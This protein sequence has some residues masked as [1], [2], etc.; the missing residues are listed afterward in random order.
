[1]A[2]V[3]QKKLR[4]WEEQVS[5]PFKAWAA[6]SNPAA[7]T[8]NFGRVDFRH[9]R[10]PRRFESSTSIQLRRQFSLL[11][12]PEISSEAPSEGSSRGHPA[13]IR[14]TQSLVPMI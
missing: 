6:G 9:P 2:P 8:M 14:A 5:D 10:A 1:M 3:T 12:S 11:I 13:A 7:L 4:L